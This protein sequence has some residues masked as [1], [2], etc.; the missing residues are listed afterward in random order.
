MAKN[1]LKTIVSTKDT[2]KI[3][4]DMQQKNMRKHLWLV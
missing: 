1:F 2:V 4:Q 3:R